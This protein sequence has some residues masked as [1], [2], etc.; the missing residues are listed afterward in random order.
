MG[1]GGDAES[2][3]DRK[4]SA[5]KFECGVARTLECTHR[6]HSRLDRRDDRDQRVARSR[7]PCTQETKR[8]QKSG[9]YPYARRAHY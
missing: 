3:T 9:D 4:P 5:K 6:H 7:R 2:I 1:V 8:K